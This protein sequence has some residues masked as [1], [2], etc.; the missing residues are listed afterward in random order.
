MNRPF[1]LRIARRIVAVYLGVLFMLMALERFLMYPSP[2]V[3]EGSWTAA[4]FGAVETTFDAADGTRIHGWYFDHPNPQAH[5]LFCHG[6]GEHLG[7][8]GGEMSALSK[9]LEVSLLVF[10]YRGYGHSEGKPF[11][12]GVLQD[13]EAAQRWLA[14]HAGIQPSDVV[15]YGRSLG[16]GVAVYLASKLGTRA[17]VLERTFHSMVEIGAGQFPWLPVRWVM[18][19]RYPAIDWIRRYDGP[20]LQLHGS[21]DTLVPIESARKL[22][23]ACPS[24]RKSFIE[25]PGMGHNSATPRAF[26]NDVKSLLES[27]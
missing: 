21:K 16:G 15:L 17:L 6:N 18:R 9:R 5:V 10:D 27:L 22:Y 14:G 23:E 24:V 13:G 12:A 8:L 1:W 2:P 3:S 25:V 11:E 19:N 26:L 4:E 20:L 7:Y